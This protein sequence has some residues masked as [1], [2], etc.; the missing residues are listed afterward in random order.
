VVLLLPLLLVLAQPSPA[1]H[2][3]GAQGGVDH[4]VDVGG[5]QTIIPVRPPALHE[6][7]GAAQRAQTPSAFTG[8]RPE[9]LVPIVML[10]G[11]RRKHDAKAGALHREEPEV[12]GHVES[13][14]RAVVTI[15]V[16][17]PANV[18]LQRNAVENPCA[19]PS[20]APDVAGAEGVVRVLEVREPRRC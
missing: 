16:A 19:E 17:I 1:Q 8:N 10:V 18:D 12:A 3:V 9:L 4:T 20:F 5:R 15:V 6:Q 13:R 7:P 14:M 11:P 2:D